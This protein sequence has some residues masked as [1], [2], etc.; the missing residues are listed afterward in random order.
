[1]NASQPADEKL[2]IEDLLSRLSRKEHELEELKFKM[3]Q[4]EAKLEALLI[5]KDEKIALLS[6]TVEESRNLLFIK[7]LEEKLEASERRLNNIRKDNLKSINEAKSNNLSVHRKSMS[8]LK[9]FFNDKKQLLQPFPKSKKNSEDNENL[10]IVEVLQKAL[11]E[12]EHSRSALVVQNEVL[13]REIERMRILNDKLKAE[14]RHYEITNDNLMRELDLAKMEEASLRAQLKKE[15]SEKISIESI[16][17]KTPTESEDRPKISDELVAKQKDLEVENERLRKQFLKMKSDMEEDRKLSESDISFLRSHIEILRNQ[18]KE[19]NDLM[20]ARR[21]AQMDT[22]KELCDEISQIRKENDQKLQNL[23]Q[24]I[25]QLQN[26]NAKTIIEEVTLPTRVEERL[27]IDEI[28]HI[29][30]I[31]NFQDDR[32]I[33]MLPCSASENSVTRT[34][35]N[36]LSLQNYNDQG[37]DDDQLLKDYEI[38]L[39]ELDRK[40]EEVH[41]LRKELIELRDRKNSEDSSSILKEERLKIKH[42]QQQMSLEISHLKQE[43]EFLRNSNDDLTSEVVKMKVKYSDLLLE[44][45]MLDQSSRRSIRNLE[46]VIGIYENQITKFNQKISS[47]K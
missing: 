17:E 5:Q 32:S 20:E 10:K 12:E 24:E 31:E 45:D 16:L 39:A 22:E 33:E 6:S 15:I 4:K 27:L 3:T 8:S 28:N 40:N 43:I 9:S 2:N 41:S 34:H 1:M 30:E 38:V 19:A 14:N 35:K 37:E 13:E 26:M 47:K 42:L 21:Q 36:D 23:Q 11:V 7:E 18:L 25:E 44:N 46:N 29:G